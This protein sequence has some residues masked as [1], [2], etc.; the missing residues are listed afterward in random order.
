M[1]TTEQT[2]QFSD[3]LEELGN[4]LDITKD[5]HDAA[6]KSYRFVGEWLADENSPLAKYFPEI[7]PQGSFL[8]G[9][10]TRPLLDAD[11]LDI[12]LVCR[13]EGKQP[14][15]TQYDLKKIVGDRL[16][17]NGILLKLLVTPDGRR[18]WT[19][20]Y[21]DSAKFHMD[22]LPSIV[23]SGYRTI[24]NK[25]LSEKVADTNSLAIRITD[26]KEKN[27]L[28]STSPNEW[29]KTNPFGY[30]IW[31]EQ[32]ASLDFQKAILLSESVAP[33]PKFQAKKLP[34]QRVVQIL[35]RHRDI[36][37]NGDD[38]KPISIIITTLA[39]SSYN[40][41]TDILTALTNV[42]QQMPNRI[43]ERFSAKHGRMIKW[44]PNPVNAEENFADKWA[45]TPRKQTL[46]YK[47][48]EE[49]RLD[50]QSVTQQRGIN[51]IQ[52]SFTKSF[53]KNSVEKAFNSY[54]EN[55][56][57]LREGGNQ[58]MTKTTGTLGAIGT[59]KNPN[60]NFHGDE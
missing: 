28:V 21:A 25:A 10:M 20:Q 1:L 2:K 8:L 41:E 11:E 31:F 49:V 60:H 15:W 17:A 59:V 24:L 4:A 13:L 9:T 14:L 55:L 33:V 16:K 12:D 30:G 7:L 56:R 23:S 18:C 26:K 46:F 48:L 42:I 53:G 50:I 58:F 29:L 44:V 51:L 6:V 35:K 40:K 5:Q 52:E 32:R 22:I 3:I 19:L 38:D 37:F 36:K 54:G 47:W 43:E 27:Y 39:A 34:L 45:E 57:K